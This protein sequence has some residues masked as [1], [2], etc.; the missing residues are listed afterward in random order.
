[1]CVVGPAGDV[2]LWNRAL[3]ELTGIAAESAF[4]KPLG[5]LPEPWGATL[6][7]LAQSEEAQRELELSIAGRKRSFTWY[8]AA[9]ASPAAQ[10]GNVMLLEDRT[11][12]RELEAKVAHQDRLASIG[13]LAAG[14]AHEIGNP[15]TAVT[16]VAQN[17]KADVPDDE[18]RERLQ[19]IIAQ[20]RR[21][22]RIVRGLLGFARAGSGPG[23]EAPFFALSEMVDDAVTL[24][25]LARKSRAVRIETA[26]APELM[27]RGDR[28]RLEQVLVNLLNNACDAS[29]SGARVLVRAERAGQ[30]VRIAVE[31]QGTGMSSEVQA[32]V[33]EPFFT[34][35]HAAEGSG[36]GMS[37]AYG[38]V[39]QHGG[40]LSIQSQPGVGTTV[41]VDLPG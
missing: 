6:L 20:A 27:L 13:R 16:S 8:R 19:L 17:L 29:Q 35:K 38:I 18:L 15:L 4:G 10:G 33:F 25:Q 3:S 41:T 30:G 1:V 39:T 22:D 26:L 36:L 14:V 21:I 40:Q 28:Q 12:A 23:G 9:V 37:V 11:L 31:D 2:A 24:A 7:G 5:E 34:T 32:R